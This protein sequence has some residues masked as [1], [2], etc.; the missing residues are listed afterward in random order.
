[1]KKPQFGV[2]FE[3]ALEF[4]LQK[5]KGQKRKGNNM[6]YFWHPMS[7]ARNVQEVK[8]STNL[9]LL[10]TAAILHDTVEDC[11]D[12]TIEEIAKIF[13]YQVAS[14]V[15]ELT[16]DDAE[17]AKVGKTEYL[18]NKMAGMSSYALVIKLSDRRDNV[19][20]LNSMTQEFKER[21]TKETIE[22]LDHLESWVRK[23][24]GTHI[25]LIEKIRKVLKKQSEVKKNA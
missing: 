10:M 23:L 1:M 12:V 19:R 14:L 18:K 9:E 7:V 11:T 21:Y 8:D 13:G 16:S 17:I 22:I 15:S 4:A 5:H 3:E 25:K 6:P 2:L 24:T 20:D